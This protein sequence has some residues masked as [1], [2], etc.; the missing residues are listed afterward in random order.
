M[1]FLYVCEKC[2][3]EL[4]SAF[5]RSTDCNVVSAMKKKKKTVIMLSP[6]NPV[7]KIL[8]ISDHCGDEMYGKNYGEQAEV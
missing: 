2:A 5:H 8:M 6:N 4:T 7:I 3:E 1:V